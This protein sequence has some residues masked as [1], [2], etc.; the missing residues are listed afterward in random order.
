MTNTQLASIAQALRKQASENDG[1]LHLDRHL[2]GILLGALDRLAQG[3]ARN[4]A[5]ARAIARQSAL[6]VAVARGDVISLADRR[7]VQNWTSGDGPE[8]AA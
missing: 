8:D 6:V 7:M 1:A 2:T 5:L 3:P 4:A